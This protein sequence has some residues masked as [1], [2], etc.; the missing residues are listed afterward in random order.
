M[1]CVSAEVE[2]LVA[3]SILRVGVAAVTLLCHVTASAAHNISIQ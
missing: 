1:R 2:C 3:D